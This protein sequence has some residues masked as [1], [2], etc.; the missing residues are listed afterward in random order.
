MTKV[1]LDFNEIADR[2]VEIALKKLGDIGTH[3]H[4]DR[5]GKSIDH[6]GLCEECDKWLED[7]YGEGKKNV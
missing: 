4:C 7:N 5:C 3:Y 6:Y 2:V 1:V